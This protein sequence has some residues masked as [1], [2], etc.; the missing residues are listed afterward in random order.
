MKDDYFILFIII[1]ISLSLFI[2]IY[3]KKEFYNKEGIDNPF[4]FII[5]LFEMLAKIGLNIV[6]IFISLIQA[7]IFISDIFELLRCPMSL[8]F[9]FP[10]CIY[11]F[12]LDIICGLLYYLLWYIVYIFLYMPMCLVFTLMCTISSTGNGL[13][14]DVASSNGCRDLNMEDIFFSKKDFFNF[15]DNVYLLIFGSHLLYRDRDDMGKCYCLEPIRLFFS[16]L[17]HFYNFYGM[18]DN[19]NNSDVFY[20]IMTIIIMILLYITN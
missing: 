11:F 15:I 4:S 3:V 20:I 2:A 9:N 6:Q 17:D 7:F 1:L 8:F 19:T 10:L 18:T 13:L 14:Y 16:P 12:A 5:K